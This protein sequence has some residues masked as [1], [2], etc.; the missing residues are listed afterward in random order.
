MVSNLMPGPSSLS[1]WWAKRVNHCAKLPK[2]HK[3]R[4]LFCR[5]RH[6]EMAF[7]EVCLV[8][9]SCVYFTAIYNGCSNKTKTFLTFYATKCSKIFEVFWQPSSPVSI[10][11]LHHFESRE[12][13]VDKVGG[14]GQK[15]NNNLECFVCFCLALRFMY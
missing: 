4:E 1:K 10:C 6:G 15:S 14:K 5:V 8:I 3:N 11:M 9:G 12:V 2:Y 13:S 7:S